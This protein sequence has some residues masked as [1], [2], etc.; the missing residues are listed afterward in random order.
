M[1]LLDRLT[2][3]GVLNAAYEWLCRR[4]LRYSA[5][6]DVWSLRRCW[7]QE[8]QRIVEQ[9]RAGCY[10]FSL[11]SRIILGNGEEIDLWS[12]RD[13]LVLKARS[14]MLGAILPVSS[15]YAHVK[16]HGGAR[17][18]VREVRAHLPINRFVL[19]T[20]VK[21]YYASIDHV[22]LMDRLAQFVRDPIVL[23]L[24]GQYLKRTAERA[25]GFGA[26]TGDFRW[27]AP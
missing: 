15:R 20:D 25:G 14:I 2:C 19:R 16:G 27:A 18:A 26:T 9:L 4:R 5:D 11:L 6:S 7:P 21:S 8:K 22:L 23:N 3:D 13:A 1:T 17:S 24:C 12:A 10:C